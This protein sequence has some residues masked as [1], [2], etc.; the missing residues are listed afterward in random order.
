MLE[1][2]VFSNCK[3]ITNTFLVHCFAKINR[4]KE[5]RPPLLIC[6]KLLRTFFTFKYNYIDSTTK[7]VEQKCTSPTDMYTIQEYIVKNDSLM[8]YKLHWIR[9]PVNVSVRELP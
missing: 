7:N 6:C 1:A 5:M 9:C 8:E 3:F 4:D 2:G